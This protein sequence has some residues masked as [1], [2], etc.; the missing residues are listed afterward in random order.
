NQSLFGDH[1]QVTQS[2]GA[3]STE[4][5]LTKEQ[6]IE[7]L[8][9]LEQLV[10][11]TELPEDIKEEASMYLGAAKKATAKEEPKKETALAN[12]ESVA[13]TLEVDADNHFWN[14]AKP[15]ISNVAGWLGAASGSFL[16]A[17]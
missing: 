17:L 14:Q 8:A 6:V 5:Q 9:E 2:Q 11:R 7:L 15:I 3:A 16:L 4:E 12:L 13:E 1:N 10:Q